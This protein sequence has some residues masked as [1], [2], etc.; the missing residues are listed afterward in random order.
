MTY[1]PYDRITTAGVSDGRPNNTGGTITKGVPVRINTSGELD[2][3]DVSSENDSLNIIGVAADN[4][5]T[6]STGEVVSSGKVADIATFAAF[7]DVLY[8]DKSGQLTNIKPAIGIN[9]F[10]SGDFVII[11]GVVAKNVDNPGLKDLV[12]NIQ[13]VGQL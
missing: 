10:V 5:P 1:R 8:I 2:G 6:S 3:I 4:I 13:V 9:G 11:V 12:L 7:G